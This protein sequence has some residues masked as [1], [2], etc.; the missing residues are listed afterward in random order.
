MYICFTT[1]WVCLSLCMNVDRYDIHRADS[2]LAPSQWET[3]LQNNAVSH[4]LGANLALS[5]YVYVCVMYEPFQLAL[6]RVIRLLLSVFR[7]M[8]SR[9]QPVPRPPLAVSPPYRRALWIRGQDT[10]TYNVYFT[11]A[12]N[13]NQLKSKQRPPACFM[14]LVEQHGLSW[15]LTCCHVAWET[16]THGRGRPR[17]IGVTDFMPLVP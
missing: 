2:G 11:C 10:P 7:S 3:S 9:R 5:V 16:S 13:M 15:P 6:D 17:R 12:R 8:P 4:W 1:A 14:S